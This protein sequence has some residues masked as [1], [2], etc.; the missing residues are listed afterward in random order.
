M[1]P[2]EPNNAISVCDSSAATNVP[3]VAPA[4]A[5]A[6]RSRTCTA[7]MIRNWSSDL[8]CLALNMV[9]LLSGNK[10]VE[11]ERARSERDRARLAPAEVRLHH[12]GCAVTGGTHDARG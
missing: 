12:P 9:G 2:S 1:K 3:H 10:C 6:L 11:S 7:R 5:S 4:I 8:T